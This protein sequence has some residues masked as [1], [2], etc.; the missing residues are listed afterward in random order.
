MTTTAIAKIEPLPVPT[1]VDPVPRLPTWIDSLANSIRE[2][3]LHDPETG[4]YNKC[5][6]LVPERMPTSDQRYELEK[7]RHCLTTLLDQQ[8]AKNR[9]CAKK[10][11]G[12]IANL[13]LAKPARA[14]G[15]ETAKA[16]AKAYEIALA[17]VPCW[18]IDLAIRSWYCGQCDREY[19]VPPERYDYTWAP[20][21]A[22]LRKLALRE[23]AAVHRRLR[24]IDRVLTAIPYR[25]PELKE[26][27]I[28]FVGTEQWQA[29]ADWYRKNGRELKPF[30]PLRDETGQRRPAT[31]VDAEWPPSP[32][33]EIERAA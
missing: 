14:G 15:P 16:R 29:W 33:V 6:T 28:I 24:V 7:H 2:Q 5:L 1:P 23:V 27:H 31:V 26:R 19:A 17:D 22:I 3:S 8:P 20:E 9:E 12:L 18:S 32:P 4:N 11:F 13:M 21:S 25:A 10:T 30:W